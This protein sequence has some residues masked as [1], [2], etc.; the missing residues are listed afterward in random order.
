MLE[1]VND[2]PGRDSEKEWQKTLN[3]IARRSRKSRRE[4]NLEGGGG[5]GP[6][7]PTEEE[8]EGNADRTAFFLRL[9]ELVRRKSRESASTV[10]MTLPMPPPSDKSSSSSSSSPGAALYMAWL[11]FVSRDFESF[12]FVRG[13]QESVLTFYS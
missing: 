3:Q 4:S 11:E 10:I 1:G 6:P 13:N 7:R 2:P 12:L 5:E 9:S 8:L